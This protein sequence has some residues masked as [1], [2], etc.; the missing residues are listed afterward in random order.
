MDFRYLICSIFFL[1]PPAM[2][3][4]P[5]YGDYNRH[6]FNTVL[7]HQATSEVAECLALDISEGELESPIKAH[8]VMMASTLLRYEIQ[9]INNNNEEDYD[10]V[11]YET[12][13]LSSLSY[14]Q[15]RVGVLGEV[16][17]NM[18][19]GGEYEGFIQERKRQLGCSRNS[20]VSSVRE[21]DDKSS[22]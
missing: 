11:N 21:L 1:M 19:G 17:K 9:P 6:E 22:S 5:E 15:G 7:N 12:A 16:S 4:E 3:Q 2:A 20:I 8:L 14:Y 13:F 18:G 10:Y